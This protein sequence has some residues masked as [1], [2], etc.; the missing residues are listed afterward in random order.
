MGAL[1]QRDYA[2]RVPVVSGDELGDLARD[3]NVM[4]QTLE[5]QDRQ[6]RQWLADMSHELR[7]P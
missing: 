6:Q 3:F 4:A 5:E 7:T 2:R 1:M